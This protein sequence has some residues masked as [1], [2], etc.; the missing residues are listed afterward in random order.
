MLY[1][2]TN[3]KQLYNEE[4]IYEPIMFFYAKSAKM[5]LTLSLPAHCDMINIKNMFN[6]ILE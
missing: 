5:N 4:K 3:A 2:G 6:E 1:L